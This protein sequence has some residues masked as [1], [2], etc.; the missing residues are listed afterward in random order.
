MR[1]LSIF[2]YYCFGKFLP[3][4]CKNIR[5]FLAK[6]FIERMGCN[7]NIQRGCIFSK[8]LSI[9]DNSGLGENSIL[10]GKITI[11]NN[12]MMGRECYI[13][14]TNH[15]H[16]SLDIPMIEQGYEK[17]R[18]VIIDD[19]VW[20]GSRVTILPGVHVYQGAIIGA[21]AV[22]TKDVEKYSIVA[23]NPAQKVKNR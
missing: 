5:S 12:V 1:F 6:N 21:S 13:Y 19:D 14:T 15:C 18:E 23:G 17:E 9:G 8:K 11:G 20:I 10:Q 3:N 22:V 7:V 16:D 2:L 4:S